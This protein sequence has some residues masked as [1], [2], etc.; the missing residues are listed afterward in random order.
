[1]PSKVYTTFWTW[2]LNERE[3]RKTRSMSGYLSVGIMTVEL[4]RLIFGLCWMDHADRSSRYANESQIIDMTILCTD[5]TLLYFYS[6]GLIPTFSFI[7]TNDVSNVV[8]FLLFNK[9][10][11]KYEYYGW[12]YSTRHL[13]TKPFNIFT[14][15]TVSEAATYNDVAKITTNATNAIWKYKTFTIV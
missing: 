11:V 15:S 3:I 5:F 8:Y 14:K 6:I 12:N 1:M 13:W 2:F 4:K 10:L 7:P 9:F